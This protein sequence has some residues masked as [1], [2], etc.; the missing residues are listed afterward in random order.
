MTFDPKRLIRFH[1]LNMSQASDTEKLE[2][3][4]DSPVSHDEPFV[5]I[6]QGSP[7]HESPIRA[8]TPVNNQS[9][10]RDHEWQSDRPERLKI[11][12]EKRKQEI[13]ELLRTIADFEPRGNLSN[14]IFEINIA[15]RMLRNL[16]E[17]VENY[18]DSLIRNK[19]RKTAKDF[20]ADNNCV[21]WPEIRECLIRRYGETRSEDILLNEL[22]NSVQNYDETYISF[23]DKIMTKA[24]ALTE[25]INFK[26][27]DR[28]DWLK[29]KKTGVYRTNTTNF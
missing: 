24:G 5:T 6:D 17:S 12:V 14:F 26:Y 16:P 21:T 4:R 13:V 20:I 9:Q 27:G 25:C 3:T 18:I 29:F 22:K 19:I 1:S 7:V 8:S 23:F 15:H 11:N 10:L 28:V 2:E